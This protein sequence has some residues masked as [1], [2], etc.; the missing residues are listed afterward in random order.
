MHAD[1]G[2]KMITC[3]LQFWQSHHSDIEDILLNELLK[4]KHTG[5]FVHLQHHIDNGTRC[6]PQQ[7]R[8]HEK[9][10]TDYLLSC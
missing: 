7:L 9:T 5:D 8:S 3:L 2:D 6:K 10:G 4:L 1:V